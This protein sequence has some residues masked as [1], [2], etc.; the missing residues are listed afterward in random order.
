M[1][2]ENESQIKLQDILLAISSGFFLII[3]FPHF[4]MEAIVWFS[5]IPLFWAIQEKRLHHGFYLGAITGFVFFLGLVYWVFIA[6]SRYGNLNPVFSAFVLILLVS[7]LSLFIGTFA[8]LVRYLKKRLGSSEVIT[9]PFTWVSLEY[10]RSFLFTGF[11][12]ESLGYS[13][14]LFLPLVQVS[15]VTGVYGISFLIVFVNALLFN[16]SQKWLLEGKKNF[17]KE[18]AFILLLFVGTL[19]YGVWR[20]ADINEISHSSP[21]I[22]VA[23]IQG[24]IDQSKKWDKAYQDET[25]RIYRELSFNAAQ[26]NP[27]LIVW[28]ETAT[29]FYFQS[30]NTYRDLIFD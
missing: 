11:P 19:T 10:I 7:Y 25:I 4:N 20:L 22:K 30:Y 14:F 28:P 24:N 1:I 26:S 18:I 29:P 23:L 27:N 3:I 8:F 17:Y 5:L 16:I 21:T 6:V 12:W 15:D 9:A 2:T 13:Q